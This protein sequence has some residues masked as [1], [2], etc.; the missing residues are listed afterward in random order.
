MFRHQC[1][2]SGVFTTTD[3]PNA[4]HY[5]RLRHEVKEDLQVWLSFLSTSFFLNEVWCNSN[6]LNLFTDASGSIGFG[7]IFGSEWCYGKW[8]DNWLHRNIAILEF[9]PIILS[10]GLWGYKMQN[11][12]VLFFTDNESLVHVINKQSCPTIFSTAPFSLP[13]SPA[14]LA[15]FIA[16]MFDQQYAPSTVNTYVSSL[17]YSHKL[18]GLP[19]PTRVFYI[20]QMLKGYGKKGFRLDCR[21]P[22]TLPILK[23]LLEISPHIT[24]SQYQICQ[25]RAMCS[26]AFF[27]FLRIGKIT[28]MK[29]SG[30]QPL[31]MHQ[32]AKTYDTCNQ[33]DGI[34]LTFLDFK[35]N[36]DKRSFTLILKRQPNSC[37]IALLL[38]F[39][40]QRG[41][42][43][44]AIFLTQ[45]GA[46]ITRESFASRLIA[47][48]RYCGPDPTWYKGH[49]F[50]I[51]AASFAAEQGMSD[52]QIH[53]LGCWQLNAF[54]Q[55]IQ[56][57][58]M[59][60]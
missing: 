1:T 57:P 45:H 46:P 29:S 51:G 48:I 9:Y 52:A 6:K 31:Q 47:A 8:P 14:M 15:L 58:S 56:V 34:K 4:W 11:H 22:I 7:A 43:Q 23:N 16:Y 25:F 53:T 49:S 35:H 41:N 12:S 10:L 13:I 21:L 39:L 33:V 5:I 17:S 54:H 44:R 19:D 24:G 59:T 50:R 55:Y 28:T 27:A 3:I 26:L 36:Y 2:W 32:L 42:Q 37:P 18:S 60:T 30:C 38:D 20:V 40:F